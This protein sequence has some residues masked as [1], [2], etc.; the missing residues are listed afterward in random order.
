MWLNS[1][2]SFPRPVTLYFFHSIHFHNCRPLWYRCGVILN[3][4]DGFSPG[5]YCH[6]VCSGDISPAE[7]DSSEQLHY[8]N[9]SMVFLFSFALTKEGLCAASLTGGVPDHSFYLHL[10]RRR[11][12]LRVTTDVLFQI[13]GLSPRQE[14]CLLASA[15]PAHP[16]SHGPGG[17]QSVG[18]IPREGFV[19]F[20]VLPCSSAPTAT[21]RSVRASL[22][23]PSLSSLG[24]FSF[25]QAANDDGL[26][27][28]SCRSVVPT[29]RPVE[30]LQ[31]SSTAVVPF[32][33]FQF[34]Y[35]SPLFYPCGHFNCFWTQG[36]FYTSRF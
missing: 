34:R 3:F 28:P 2:K 33:G 9:C 35:F 31:V 21:A 24:G 16:A 23:A 18:C 19:S 7:P 12:T 20:G 25:L 29:L 6:P 27:S 15:L 4:T 13:P 17:L 30:R 8:L 1:T 26:V 22:E 36:Y 10:K 14:G 32:S 11:A 5:S